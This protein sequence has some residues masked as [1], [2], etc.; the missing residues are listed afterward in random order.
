MRL[1]HPDDDELRANFEELL[2][3]VRNG[4]GIYTH[5]GVDME[6]EDALWAIAKAYPHVTD[7]LVRSARKTFEGQMDGSNSAARR[8]ALERKFEEYTRARQQQPPQPP[9]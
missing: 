2:S 8:A 3:S 5:S 9:N 7:E 1:K 4:G 6:T